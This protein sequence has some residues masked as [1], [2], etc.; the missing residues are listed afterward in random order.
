MWPA[1]SASQLKNRYYSDE[2]K[3]KEENENADEP[4]NVEEVQEDIEGTHWRTLLSFFLCKYSSVAS[5]VWMFFLPKL[6]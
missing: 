6:M 2:Q 5:F 3:T 1:S 4:E